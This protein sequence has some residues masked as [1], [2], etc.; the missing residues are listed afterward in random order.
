MSSTRAASEV[1]KSQA[2]AA[3]FVLTAAVLAA[4]GASALDEKQEAKTFAGQL[5][6]LLR[7]KAMAL[8]ELDMLYCYK[9]GCTIRDA[10]DFIGFQGSLKDFMGDYKQF[11]YNEAQISLILDDAAAKVEVPLADEL[12]APK[13]SPAISEAETASAAGTHST[14]DEEFSSSDAESEVDIPQWHSVGSR[15]AA[16]L[17][18]ATFDSDDDGMDLWATSVDVNAWHNVGD[19]LAFAFQRASD[20]PG[21]E[22]D[23]E[24]NPDAAAWHDVGIRMVRRLAADENDEF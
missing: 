12:A 11:S 13:Y 14:T 16:A 1:S 8:D 6:G 21:D 5:I 24:N 19:R 15:L 7:E 4:G 2:F 22:S 10:L 23:E 17:D 3:D 20:D 18:D 9:F